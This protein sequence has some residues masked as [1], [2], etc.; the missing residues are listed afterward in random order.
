MP[1]GDDSRCNETN[2]FRKQGVGQNLIRVVSFSEGTCLVW[3]K[4][5]QNN[6]N[7]HRLFGG[8]YKKT[9]ASLGPRRGTFRSSKHRSKPEASAFG[10]ST[11]DMWSARAVSW[12][13][14]NTTSRFHD[15]ATPSV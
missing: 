3:F 9:P 12:G 1:L 6:R 10:H 7:T 11:P 5:K 8:R 15:T 13:M 14:L 4:K 2:F